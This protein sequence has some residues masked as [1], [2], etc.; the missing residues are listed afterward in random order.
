MS[1]SDKKDSWENSDIAAALED[2]RRDIV[3]TF[4]GPQPQRIRGDR[5][6]LGEFARL[7]KGQ[8]AGAAGELLDGCKWC[9][10]RQQQQ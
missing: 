9:G 1:I 6:A 7:E 10:Q 4:D 8:A 5:E 2:F 3:A